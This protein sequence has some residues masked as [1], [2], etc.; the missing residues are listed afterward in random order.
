[1]NDAQVDS[2]VTWITEAG[3][4]GLGE[5]AILT[6]LCERLLALGVPRARANVVIDTLHPFTRAALSPG[7]LDK[8]ETMLAEFG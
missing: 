1:M 8:M 2:L 7:N 4:S 6:L 3:L 5:S